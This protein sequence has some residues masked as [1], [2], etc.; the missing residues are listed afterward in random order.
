MELNFSTLLIVVAGVMAAINA[1]VLKLKGLAELE[2]SVKEQAYQLFL[3]AEK[4][5]WIGQEKMAYVAN[6][7]YR[8]IPDG[9]LKLVIKEDTIANYLQS[10]YD[11]FKTNLVKEVE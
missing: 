5:G 11:Q 8:R 2:H 1:Y 9:V 4:Q 6:E 7:I 10:L 3:Y